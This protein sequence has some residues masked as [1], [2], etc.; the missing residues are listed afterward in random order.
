[1]AVHMEALARVRARLCVQIAGLPSEQHV[2][3]ADAGTEV[4]QSTLAEGSGPMPGVENV[5]TETPFCR[6]CVEA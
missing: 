2:W 1:M 5:D 4:N 6:R 3:L